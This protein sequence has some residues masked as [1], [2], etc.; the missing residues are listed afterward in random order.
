MTGAISW[1]A[2]QHSRLRTDF[3]D[4]VHDD[5]DNGDHSDGDD[6]GDGDYDNDDNDVHD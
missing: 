1:A 3:D 2:F 6:Q 5:D 4:N